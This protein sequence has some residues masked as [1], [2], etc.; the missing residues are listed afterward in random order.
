MRHNLRQAELSGTL[1]TIEMMMAIHHI[2][3][4]SVWKSRGECIAQ[5]LCR[6]SIQRIDEDDSIRRDEEDRSLR[7]RGDLEERAADG[8]DL[9]IHG[10]DGLRV[11]TFRKDANACERG[12]QRQEPLRQFHALIEGERRTSGTKRR[13]R[14]TE[15]K[16]RRG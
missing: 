5:P 10:R 1:G 15:R 9:G 3:N 11:S 8:P 12:Q 4:G 16:Y 2:T 14:C 13:I 6:A 7:S